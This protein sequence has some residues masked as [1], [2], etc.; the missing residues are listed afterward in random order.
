MQNTL[1]ERP[2]PEAGYSTPSYGLPVYRLPVEILLI[3][4]KLATLSRTRQVLYTTVKLAHVCHQWRASLIGYTQAWTSIFATQ[5][6]RPSFIKACFRRSQP[7]PIEITVDVGDKQRSPGIIHTGVLCVRLPWP[8]NLVTNNTSY[9]NYSVI[10]ALQIVF[11]YY[12]EVLQ[13]QALQFPKR[14]AAILSVRIS[15]NLPPL[16]GRKGERSALQGRGGK[17]HAACSLATVSP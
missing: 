14:G 4:F 8:R 7:L 3:I 5:Q 2:T 15:R 11:K 9:L 1:K 16:S 10:Q 17:V 13:S 6:D 12:A